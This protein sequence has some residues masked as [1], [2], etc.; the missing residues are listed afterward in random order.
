MSSVATA[1]P[2]W[3]R[4]KVQTSKKLSNLWDHRRH[5]HRQR[6][7][8]L[9]NTDDSKCKNS[10]QTL[11]GDSCTLFSTLADHNNEH[12]NLQIISSNSIH[13]ALCLVDVQGLSTKMEFKS[14]YNGISFPAMTNRFARYGEELSIGCHCHVRIHSKMVLNLSYKAQ[15]QVQGLG[16]H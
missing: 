14:A 7:Y 6:R 16:A 10:V 5:T 13:W 4:K 3:T 11:G 2:R 9:L 12:A 1:A 8:Q 15:V